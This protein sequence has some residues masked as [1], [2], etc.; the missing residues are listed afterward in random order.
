MS[1]TRVHKNPVLRP[2]ERG[3]SMIEL[4]VALVIALFLLN[5]MFMILQNTRNASDNTNAISQLQDEERMAMTMLTDVIQQAGYYPNWTVTDLTT[6]LPASADFAAAGQSVFGVTNQSAYGDSVS[7]RYMGDGNVLDCQ[8]ST[9]P[10]NTVREMTFYVGKGN[11]NGGASQ[12]YCAI[13]GNL[14]GLPLIPNV[15]LLK[16]QYGIDS[17]GSNSTNAYLRADQVS[18]VLWNSVLS[19]KVAL[20]FANPLANQAGQGAKQTIPF[21]RVIAVQ[22]KTGQNIQTIDGAPVAFK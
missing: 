21:N 8:G 4:S 14:P 13:D 20:S 11:N 3:F 16:V 17:N 1:D 22:Q 12:L 6:A 15:S 10:N 5:G 18:A 9:I 2:R 19:V 7:V